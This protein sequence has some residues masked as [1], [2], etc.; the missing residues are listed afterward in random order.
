[1]RAVTPTRSAWTASTA[2]TI[3]VNANR[4]LPAYRSKEGEVGY[5]LRL[6][7]INFTADI[8]RLERPFANYVVGVVVVAICVEISRRFG[9][10]GHHDPRQKDENGLEGQ[11]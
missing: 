3:I 4:A 11:G 2:T 6:H 10:E 7:R 8:F 1:M 9:K 5:K